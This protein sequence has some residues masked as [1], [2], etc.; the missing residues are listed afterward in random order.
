MAWSREGLKYMS[1][2]RTFY[3]NGGIVGV[4]HF[5]LK[6]EMSG[7]VKKAVER[8]RRAFHE[9]NFETLGNVA[10]LNMGKVTPL[11][12]VLRSIQQGGFIT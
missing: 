8:T 11:F 7:L 12:R 9:I 5:R 2:L 3:V 4:E 1:K 6:Q 10:S